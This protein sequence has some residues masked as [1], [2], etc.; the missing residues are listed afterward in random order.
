MAKK[1]ITPEQMAELEATHKRIAYCASDTVTADG[2]PE[3]EIVLRRPSRAEYKMYRSESNDPSRV[4]DSQ[5][6]QARRTVV[7]PS[8]EQFDAMLDDFP[9][10]AEACA[11][12][13]NKLAGIAQ[14]DTG[15]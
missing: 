9:G 5:E 15:K 11:A 7:W 1:R 3:W 2:F 12:P 14:V 4:A 6:R 8:H 13:L 10:I